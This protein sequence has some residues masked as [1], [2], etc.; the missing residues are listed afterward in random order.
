[1]QSLLFYA[2]RLVATLIVS[3]LP[4]FA[5]ADTENIDSK[6]AI[7][8][9]GHSSPAISGNQVCLTTPLAGNSLCLQIPHNLDRIEDKS[10]TT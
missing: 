10:A 1:M 8:G 3:A 7:P 6:T 2:A 9:E 4:T 5:T